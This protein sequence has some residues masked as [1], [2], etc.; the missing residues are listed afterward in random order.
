M[1]ASAARIAASSRVAFGSRLAGPQYAPW[2]PGTA[3]FEALVPLA[4]AVFVFDGIIQN[5]D[6]RSDNPN[7]LVRGDAIRIFDHELAF[8]HRLM[9]GWRPPW[10]LG[11]L[12]AMEAPGHHIF[13]GILRGRTVDYAPIREA[14]AGLS[15]ARVESYAEQ[16]PPQWTAG[17]AAAA[18]AIAL[19][20]EARDNIDACLAEVRRVL[21]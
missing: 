20:K 5:P 3:L 6:R 7:C 21:T 1:A 8:T 4:C 14:W 18:E 13:R 15:D 11:G 17:A 19:I 2:N 12:R 9:I 10:T 16:L